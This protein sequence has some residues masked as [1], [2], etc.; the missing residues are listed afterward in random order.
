M[1]MQPRSKQSVIHQIK[2]YQKQEHMS[3]VMVILLAASRHTHF[4]MLGR[5]DIRLQ[6][7]ISPL[8]VLRNGKFLDSSFIPLLFLYVLTYSRSC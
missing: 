8:G 4:K 2:E 5:Q 1:V 3:L 7:F 6:G